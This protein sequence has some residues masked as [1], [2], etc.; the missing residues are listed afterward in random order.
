MIVIGNGLDA[1]AEKKGFALKS[2]VTDAEKNDAEKKEK[3]AKEK[4]F[5]QLREASAKAFSSAMIVGRCG[6]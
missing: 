4:E 1:F 6:T 3:L 5:T 2:Y